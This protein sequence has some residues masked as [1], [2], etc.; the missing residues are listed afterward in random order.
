MGAFSLH[1]FARAFGRAST[2][3]IRR[4]CA[5]FLCI[6]DGLRQSE[7]R[8]L[9][10]LMQYIIDRHCFISCLFGV[11]FCSS[12]FGIGNRV[13]QNIP[14]EDCKKKRTLGQFFTKGD[15]WLR[16]Q[17]KR[18]IA[19]SGAYIAYDPFAG[20]G[21]LLHK[22]REDIDMITQIR[23]L[24][25]D[26]SLGWEWNDSLEEIPHI[27]GA[28]IITNPPYISNYSARRK[29]INESLEKYFNKTDYDDVY[30]IALDRMLEAQNNVVAIIPETFINSSYRQK[31]KL[32]SVSILEENPFY[33]TDTPVVVVCFDGREKG[34]E[35]IAVYKDSSYVCTLRDLEES[36]IKPAG[37]VDMR[38]N[39]RDG[40]LA[41]RCVD[42]TNPNDML[43]FGFKKD[44]DYDWESGIKASSRLLTLIDLDVPKEKR[45]CFIMHCN[46]I[47]NDIRN[48]SHD[49]ILSPFKGN[50]KNGVRRRRLDFYTCRAIIE[51]AYEIVLQR[52]STSKYKQGILWEQ[53]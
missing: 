2:E 37:N 4:K 28:I 35:E 44:I 33:D 23:G 5:L 9:E 3:Y 45:E 30:L 12:V 50:M 53:V 18:F 1:V 36:R 20:D 27:D 17:I 8:V 22:A 38:F 47:L 41:V 11:A 13:M 19:A 49:L 51:K 16:P 43:R 32:S 39:A 48:K 46:K 29:R 10:D 26:R 34:Y 31:S 21:C 52:K 7:I 42:S 14:V 6:E 15:C 24:D 40:W 25:I